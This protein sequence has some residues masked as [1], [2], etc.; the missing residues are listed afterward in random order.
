LDLCVG[1]LSG[2][3]SGYCFLLDTRGKESVMNEKQENVC[4]KERDVRDVRG[5]ENS[6][7]TL[8]SR[9]CELE[10]VVDLLEKELNPVLNPVDPEP[11]EEKESCEMDEKRECLL[12]SQID[13]QRARVEGI[14]GWLHGIERRLEV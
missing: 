7:G 4:T 14:V 13:E 10:S 5:V 1:F 12:V 9:I 2:V 3:G 6:M 11:V 8:V